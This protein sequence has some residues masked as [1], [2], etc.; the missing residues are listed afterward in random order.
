MLHQVLQCLYYQNG[1]GSQPANGHMVD[2]TD[3]GNKLYLYLSRLMVGGEDW[4]EETHYG[5]SCRSV[6][7]WS[8]I[9]NILCSIPDFFKQ[10]LYFIYCKVNIC[11]IA[12][13]N[14]LFV[15]IFVN[16]TIVTPQG[17]APLSY[18]CSL[19]SFSFVSSWII[20]SLKPVF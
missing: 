15:A 17:F 3:C 4:S 12:L 8:L 18:F 16:I 10:P 6:S 11:S 2:I 19:K 20:L 1:R 7:K 9:L 5:Q 14:L 13:K